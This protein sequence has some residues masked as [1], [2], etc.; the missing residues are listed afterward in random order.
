MPLRLLDVDSKLVARSLSGD[1]QAF[2]ALVARHRQHV[3][4]LACQMTGDREWAEDI[5]VEVFVEVYQSLSMFEE[6][7]RFSTWLRR[8]SVNVCLEHIRRS[9]AKRQIKECP[10]EVEEIASAT[11]PAEVV[12]SRELSQRIGAAIEA[13]SPAHRAAVALFYVDGLS[14]DEI[15]KMLGIPRNTA[16]S[17]VFHGTRALRDQ[18]QS[19]G[20][21]ES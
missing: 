18:L 20:I 17:R 8:I 14:Y 4:A 12:I 15:G 10:L 21:I 5:T 6:R 7:S 13:L 3:Y 9:K 16:R 2:D 1:S 11:D 19:Q